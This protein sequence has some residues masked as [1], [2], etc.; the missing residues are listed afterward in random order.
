VDVLQHPAYIKI[1][2][3]SLWSHYIDPTYNK[4]HLVGS[5]HRLLQCARAYGGVLSPWR[6][7][8][9]V[10]DAYYWVCSFIGTDHSNLVRTGLQSKQTVQAIPVPHVD[11][12]LDS[13]TANYIKNG[14]ISSKRLRPGPTIERSDPI[15]VSINECF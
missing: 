7:F 11:P 13:S 9:D 8:V 14:P 6:A 4:N 5:D 12:L 10:Y 3:F 2:S 15:Y 1:K